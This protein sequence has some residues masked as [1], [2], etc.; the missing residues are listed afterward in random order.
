MNEQIA[1]YFVYIIA[2]IGLTVWVANTLHQNGRVFLI[3]AFRGDEER[4]D[5]VNHLLKVGFYLINVGFFLLFLKTGER[6]EGFVG[7]IEYCAT[8]LGFV[9]LVL[10]GMHFFNMYNFDKMRK[11]G[12]APHITQLAAAGK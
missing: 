6:P 1:V 12:R 9:T 11:K 8:K 4:A 3:E 5:A 7:A 2:C 10:G